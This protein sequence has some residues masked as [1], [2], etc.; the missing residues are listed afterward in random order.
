LI[1]RIRAIVALV[2]IVAV[3]LV[4][5]APT[6]V[7]VVVPVIVAMVVTMIMAVVVTM[8]PMIVAV[9]MRTS[10]SGRRG[11]H[12]TQ[13][14]SSDSNQ[15]VQKAFHN[16]LLQNVYFEPGGPGDFAAATN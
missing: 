8:M 11:E 9:A 6:A 7:V 13:G 14:Q 16:R 3:V 1:V 5:I 12:A 10:G 2:V 4:L 15:R